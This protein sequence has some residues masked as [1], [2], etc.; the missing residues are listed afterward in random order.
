MATRD[1]IM[2]RWIVSIVAHDN[3]FYDTGYRVA[4]IAGIVDGDEENIRSWAWGVAQVYHYDNVAFIAIN[5][6]TG[7]RIEDSI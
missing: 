2:A 1:E 4:H 5:A 3:G 7:D 6:A